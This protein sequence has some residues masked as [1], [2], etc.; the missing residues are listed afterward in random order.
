MRTLFTALTGAIVSIVL[1]TSA[2]AQTS[3]VT[4]TPANLSLGASAF[5]TTVEQ[6]GL[7][8]FSYVATNS[9]Q[10]DANSVFFSVT[11]PNTTTWYMNTFDG[12]YCY[13]ALNV[14]T[15][16]GTIPRRHLNAAQT[17]FENGTAQITVIGVANQCGSSAATGLL[18]HVSGNRV[19]T[20]STIVTCPT[21]V[22]TAT[23]V[24]PTSTVAPPTPTLTPTPTSTLVPPSSAPTQ[25]APPRIAPLPPR[26]GTGLQET[27][28]VSTGFR[29]SVALLSIVGGL[30]L[31]VFLAKRRL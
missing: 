30:T 3:T 26:T 31:T 19:A 21:P 10:T 14:A 1:V 22:P 17:D 12:W 24:T 25:A 2:H 8:G 4:P 28:G 5:S 13:L 6:G 29:W 15:C 11:L 16:T 7:L 27:S 23:P 18:A 20:A 9:G